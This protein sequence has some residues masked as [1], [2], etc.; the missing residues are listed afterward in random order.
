MVLDASHGHATGS[1]G[2]LV[3]YAPNGMPLYSYTTGRESPRAAQLAVVRSMLRAILGN[4]DSRYIFYYLC[5]NVLFM[6]VEF[7]YG[8]LSN[9]LGLI[10]DG[11]HMLFD[12]TALVVGL[13]ASVMAKQRPTRRFSYGYGRTEILS[14]YINGVFL[15]LIALFVFS[16]ALDRLFDPPEIRTD[17]LL[18]VSVGGL[19]V[20]LIGIMSFRHAHS[21]AGGA[22]IAHAH[23]DL[24]PAPHDDIVGAHGHSHSHGHGH[25][26]GHADEAAVDLAHGACDEKHDGDAESKCAH[27]HHHDAMAV[28][29]NDANME[30]IFLHVLADTLGSVGVITS[31]LMIEYFGWHARGA[32]RVRRGRGGPARLTRPCRLQTRSVPCSSPASFSS[33]SSRSSALPAPSCCNVFRAISKL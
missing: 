29:H 3:G 15:I 26:H 32:R 18:A 24:T 14:G 30:G 27:D 19:L 11:F 12:C 23:G 33:A 20:N 21:H 22:G 8:L 1:H 2:Q 13:F 28:S 6:V 17:R 31:S 9:S 7:V 5:L 16:E 25:A 4:R 10:S